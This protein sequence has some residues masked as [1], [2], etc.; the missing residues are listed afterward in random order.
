MKMLQMLPYF[1]K[2]EIIEISYIFLNLSFGATFFPLLNA[3]IYV[4]IDQDI[5]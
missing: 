5:Q 1:F 2:Y 3:L 4:D